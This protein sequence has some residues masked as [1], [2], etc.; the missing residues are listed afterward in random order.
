MGNLYK[1]ADK[2][3]RVVP[4][5]VA[6]G[7]QSVNTEVEAVADDSSAVADTFLTG[8]K[9]EKAKGKSYGFYLS[10]ENVAKLKALA[11]QENVSMSKLLD[12]ILTEVLK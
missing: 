8:L 12:H 1:N 5:G 2:R 4:G 9:A 3:K 10:D 6:Q 11:K 7:E